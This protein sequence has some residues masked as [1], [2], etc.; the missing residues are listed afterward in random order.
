MRR[1]KRIPWCW[2][3]HSRGGSPTRVRNLYMNVCAL[4]PAPAYFLALYL[5]T[6]WNTVQIARAAGCSSQNVGK[7]LRHGVAC[8][9][10]GG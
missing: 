5:K 9:R 1:F 6:G 8:L 2:E 10:K 4:P 3:G 7:R